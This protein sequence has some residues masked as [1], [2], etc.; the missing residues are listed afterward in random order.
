[1]LGLQL[2]F[3]Y[4]ADD[5]LVAD[6]GFA[7]MPVE[8]VVRDYVPSTQP[9]GRMPHAWIEKDGRRISTLDLIGTDHVTLVT[10]S[11]LW[12]EAGRR[13][14]GRLVPLVVAE[15]G[16]DVVDEGGWDAVARLGADG[17]VLV[18][19]D[20]HVLWRSLNLTPDL[21][22]S[23]DEALSLLTADR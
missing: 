5:G 6:D 23:L 16:V 12:A 13:A 2:G 9:G 17:V 22:R 14:S 4:S 1:M 20:G 21:G 19:P 11:P 10:S 15:F 8:N 3:A 18:R 7:P